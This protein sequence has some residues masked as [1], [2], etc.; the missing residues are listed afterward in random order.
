MVDA[1][2]QLEKLLEKD[3]E[4]AE[5][6]KKNFKLKD[7]PRITRVGHFLR[8]TSLD[9]FPQFFNVLKGEMSVVGARPIVG[10]ELAEYYKGNGDKCGPICF[11]EAGNH[12]TMAGLKA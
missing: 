12:R 10:R 11:H 3:Q 6:W 1:D 8:H 4:L 7:D 5:E 9:E 2:L